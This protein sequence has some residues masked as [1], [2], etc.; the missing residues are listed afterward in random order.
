MEKTAIINIK[1][2]IIYWELI[3]GQKHFGIKR[4]LPHWLS[5]VYLSVFPEPFGL[6]SN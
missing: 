2:G 4:N 1:L 3:I 5:Y 6:I